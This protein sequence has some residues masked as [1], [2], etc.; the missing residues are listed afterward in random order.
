MYYS[1][2]LLNFSLCSL[3][4]GQGIIPFSL[5]KKTQP[6][7]H[8]AA[9]RMTFGLSTDRPIRTIWALIPCLINTYYDVHFELEMGVVTRGTVRRQYPDGYYQDYGTGEVWFHGMWEPH[10]W[11]AL[12]PDTEALVAMVWPPLIIDLC[13]PEAADL[14]W[15]APFV[16]PPRNRPVVP[17]ALRAE[18]RRLG[19]ALGAVLG[20]GERDLLLTRL[21]FLQLLAIVLTEPANR[22][23]RSCATPITS[24][25]L[26]P[27]LMLVFSSHEHVPLKKAADACGVSVGVFAQRFQAAMG[28]TFGQFALLRRLSCAAQQLIATDDKV[29]RIAKEWGFADESHFCRAF[30]QT[31]RCTPSNYRLAKRRETSAYTLDG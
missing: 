16:V 10:G 28:S 18:T 4:V 22:Q 17:P 11:T 25:F 3:C 26:S 7:Q 30:E 24:Q 29:K 27:A 15:M 12:E 31:Y 1:S 6:V 8:D 23:L 13:L 19:Y 20:D 14:H 9:V 5:K 2:F 21:L